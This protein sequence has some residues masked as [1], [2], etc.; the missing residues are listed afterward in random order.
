ML[1]WAKRC[2]TDPLQCEDDHYIFHITE[3]MG[4]EVR[5]FPRFSFVCDENKKQIGTQT[6]SWFGFNF[7]SK[8]L[9]VYYLLTFNCVSIQIVVAAPCI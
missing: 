1:H 3:V 6:P 8:I 2:L 7:T 4:Y 9:M 5:L